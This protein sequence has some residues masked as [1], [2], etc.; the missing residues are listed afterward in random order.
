MKKSLNKTKQSSKPS[1]PQHKSNN[2]AHIEIIGATSHSIGV[3]VAD[4]NSLE[5]DDNVNKRKEG[6]LTWQ[7]GINSIHIENSAIHRNSEAKNAVE[8]KE[9]KMQ[10]P[11]HQKLSPNA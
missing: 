8:T 5:I 10:T 6:I 7:R 9:T 4:I 11:P 1:A 2:S 3:G